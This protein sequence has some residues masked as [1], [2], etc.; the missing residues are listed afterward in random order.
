MKR[1]LFFATLALMGCEPSIPRTGKVIDKD[2]EYKTFN[3]CWYEVEVSNSLGKRWIT[4]TESF[5][6]RVNIGD[7]IN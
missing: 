4:V 2:I 3:G 7:T 6:H 5:Y 1:M